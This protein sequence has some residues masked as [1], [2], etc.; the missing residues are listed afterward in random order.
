VVDP[1]YFHCESF[2]VNDG[3]QGFIGVEQATHQAYQRKEKVGS[4]YPRFEDA[5]EEKYKKYGG[6]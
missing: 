6:A 4:G 5:H 2:I 1:A 3:E